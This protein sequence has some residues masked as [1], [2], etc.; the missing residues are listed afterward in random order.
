MD[1]QPGIGL[2]HGD[3]A[4]ARQQLRETNR[5]SAVHAGAAIGEIAEPGG[6]FEPGLRDEVVAEGREQA[7]PQRRQDEQQERCRVAINWGLIHFR[8]R[9]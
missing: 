5:L 4:E 9:L 7:P 8:C 6:V 2:K 1:R 3:P